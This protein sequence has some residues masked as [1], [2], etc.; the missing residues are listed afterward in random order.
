MK[1]PPSHLLDTSVC[2][3]PLK[4]HPS[5]S[6]LDHWDRLGEAAATS[7]ACLGEIEWGLHKLASERRWTGYREDILPSVQVLAVDRETWSHFARMK[8]RQEALGHP[9]PDLD[10]LIA[11][12]AVQHGLIL[13]TL[14]TNHF[15]LIEGLRWEDWSS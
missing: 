9:V 3:Q 11:A 13:S 10:L 2:S 5:E 12:S 15:A 4:G 14:D 1:N 7:E 8:A 6:A